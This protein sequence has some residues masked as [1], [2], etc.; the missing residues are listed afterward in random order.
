MW[1]EVPRTNSSWQQIT[2][3]SWKIAESL[4]I[5]ARRYL[6]DDPNPSPSTSEMRKPR[7]RKGK[8]LSQVTELRNGTAVTSIKVIWLSLPHLSQCVT[9]DQNSQ[10]Q[11]E[12]EKNGFWFI[13]N[14]SIRYTVDIISQLTLLMS[15]VLNVRGS[16]YCINEGTGTISHLADIFFKFRF[17]AIYIYIYVCINIRYP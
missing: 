3:S 5:S 16:I 7:S 10:G 13:S 9:Q 17:L 11:K 15:H 1:T 14:P 8:S 6:R 4:T 12:G 2:S